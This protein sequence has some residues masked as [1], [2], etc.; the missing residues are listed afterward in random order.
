MDSRF[1]MFTKIR[2]NNYKRSS[3]YM[4]EIL[5]CWSSFHLLLE[6]LAH[7]MWFAVIKSC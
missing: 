4:L 1:D 5:K 2:Q 7:S 3:N 6:R